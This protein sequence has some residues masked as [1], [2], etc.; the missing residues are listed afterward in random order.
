MM[1]KVDDEGEEFNEDQ[2]PED[3]EEDEDYLYDDDEK[4]DTSPVEN[5][6]KIKDLMDK[7]CELES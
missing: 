2:L 7:I 5:D 1:K 3:E 6:P 4:P